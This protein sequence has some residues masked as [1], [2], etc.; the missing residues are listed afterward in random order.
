MIPLNF[1]EHLIIDK[2][3]LR[4]GRGYNL[5]EDKMKKIGLRKRKGKD[6]NE[7]IY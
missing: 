2:L 5:W 3:G 6:K 7:I 1:V 4:F